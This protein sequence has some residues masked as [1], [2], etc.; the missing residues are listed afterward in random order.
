MWSSRNFWPF[1]AALK[2]GFNPI[3]RRREGL[4]T[5]SCKDFLCT[6]LREE[7]SEGNSMRSMILFLFLAANS[8]PIPAQVRV[9]EGAMDLPAYEEGAP[10]P[11]PPSDQ[12][13]I[14]PF[15]HPSTFT[16]HI[17]NH[18]VNP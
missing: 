13:P 11:N 6:L 4:S 1:F 5:V 2:R 3:H 17:T 18:S 14:S 8:L 12:F 9:W 10:D 7:P 16:K 15:T